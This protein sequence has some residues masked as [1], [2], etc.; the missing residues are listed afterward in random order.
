LSILCYVKGIPGTIQ[1]GGAAFATT[2]WS[3]VEA[4]ADDDT[5]GSRFR[6]GRT[7]LKLVFGCGIIA[8]SNRTLAL[9]GKTPATVSAPAASFGFARLPVLR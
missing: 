9:P 7:L 4:C 5:T 8:L 6:R 2:H 3:V 1:G